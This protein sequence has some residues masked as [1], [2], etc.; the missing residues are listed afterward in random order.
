RIHTRLI[1]RPLRLEPLEH[2]FIDAQGNL[3]FTKRHRQPFVSDGARPAFGGRARCVVREA[4]IGI[5]HVPDALPI[6]TI[7][8]FSSRSIGTSFAFHRVSL[9]AQKSGEQP[10]SPHPEASRRQTKRCSRACQCSETEAQG[11]RSV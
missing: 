7:L 11:R 4:N 2:V 5:R 6:R 8:N 1:A 9:S 10:C 3:P